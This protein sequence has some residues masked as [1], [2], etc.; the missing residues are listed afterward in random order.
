MLNRLRLLKNHFGSCLLLTVATTSVAEAQMFHTG[1][2]L[3]DRSTR[4]ESRYYSHPINSVTRP[5]RSLQLLEVGTLSFEDAVRASLRSRLVNSGIRIDGND[6]RGLGLAEGE[7]SSQS[8]SFSVHG[9]PYCKAQ[10]V[11]HLINDVTAPALLGNLPQF[12]P[13]QIPAPQDWPSNDSFIANLNDM[14]ASMNKHARI[15]DPLDKCIAESDGDAQVAVRTIIDIDGLLYRTLIG[16]HEVLSLDAHHFEVSGI[17]RAFNSNPFDGE[18]TDYTISTLTGDGTMTTDVFVTDTLQVPRANKV[19]HNFVYDKETTE[20]DEQSVFIHAINAL[21]WF[22]SLGY[23]YKASKKMKLK[24][25]AVINNDRNNALYTPESSSTGPT[26]QVGDGDGTFLQNLTID[27]DVVG[28]EFG[29]HIV[30]QTLKETKDD[31]LVVH[32]GLADAFTFLRTGNACLGESICP[33]N[34]PIKCEIRASCLRTAENTYKYGA[35]D[36]PKEPHFRSQFISGLI[37]DLQATKAISMSD[38]TKLLY[39]SVDFF[40][41]DSGYHDLILSLMLAD[42]DLFAGKH[43][44]AIEDAAIERGLSTVISDLDCQKSLPTLSD[45]TSSSPSSTSS[46]SRVSSSGTKE[47]S[48]CAVI[49]SSNTSGHGIWMLLTAP[50]L[51]AVIRRRRSAALES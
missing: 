35:A 43:L 30:F 42:K 19:D 39:R 2:D 18:L 33:L 50:L 24:I 17:V 13:S 44:C 8:Y 14:L 9:I 28:H 11:A 29:H 5:D 7:A 15:L 22:N 36:L 32:E 1:V 37:W 25:H 21:D 40:L 27:A 34:S 48:G 10:A 38:L 4:R 31:S 26:I 3:F 6:A 51:L 16:E 47:K 23:E 20:F 46:K 49:G 12:D 45:S 41:S